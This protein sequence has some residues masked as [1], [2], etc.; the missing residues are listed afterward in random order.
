[1]K[2]NQIEIKFSSRNKESSKNEEIG[3]YFCNPEEKMETV[4]KNFANQKNID[5][6]SANFSLNGK[7]L[8]QEDYERSISNFFS[9]LKNNILNI[10][11]DNIIENSTNLNSSSNKNNSDIDKNI[12]NQISKSDINHNKFNNKNNPSISN[13]NKNNFQKKNNNNQYDVCQLSYIQNY[14][15]N[16]SNDKGKTK[17]N[18]N[19]KIFTN[20]ENGKDTPKSER[21]FINQ[22]TKENGKNKEMEKKFNFSFFK[23]NKKLFLIILISGIIII[24]SLIVILVL[25]FTKKKK[26]KKNDDNIQFIDY[27]NN[28]K[29]LMCQE[30]I[31]SL[32]CTSCINGFELYEGQCIQHAFIATYKN[33]D[34]WTKLFNQNK[35]KDILAVKICDDISNPYYEYVYYFSYCEDNKV[36][37]Y[38]DENKNINLS[39]LF[40]GIEDIIDFSFNEDYINNF[41]ITEMQGMFMNCESLTNISFYPFEGNDL[42]NIS[43]LFSDNRYLETIDLSSL[44]LQNVKD[45]G[46]MFSDC[47]NLLSIALSN[48]NTQNAINMT[49]LFYNC[50]SLTSID[51]SNFK[52]PNAIYMNYMFY[53]CLA[54]KSLN[55]FNFNTQNAKNMSYMFS[56]CI[57][58]TSLVLSSF[59]T[60]NV[61]DMKYMFSECNSLE[62]LDLSNFRTYNVMNIA[63]MFYNCYSLK[64]LDISNFNIYNAIYLDDMFYNCSSLTGLDTSLLYT[65]NYI[66]PQYPQIPYY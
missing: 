52:T 18:I 30:S 66:Y 28:N 47:P 57:S 4:F 14:S 15:A 22:H 41:K 37:F 49:G 1:M 29:C 44:I 27:C 34:S 33:L 50:E 36:Y 31:N 19:E 6:S 38:F 10:Q 9:L 43:Y 42:L 25:I 59:N 62:I 64:D 20:D 24:I 32:L 12:N 55:L 2:R 26:E 45:M 40:K 3:R 61:K 11:V 35:E 51:L 5:L 39:Y 23:N 63:G 60:Q 53:N 16:N 8:I 54:L 21:K 13:E 65:K 46:Y 56:G 7:T 58:L 48:F 17:R